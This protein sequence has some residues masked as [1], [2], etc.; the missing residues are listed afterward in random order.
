[1]KAYAQKQPQQQSSPNNARSRAQPLAASHTVNPILH[2]QRMIGNRAVQRLLHANDEGLEAGSDNS[3]TTRFAHDFTRIS[4][5]RSRATEL[6]NE[7][8]APRNGEKRHPLDQKLLFQLPQSSLNQPLSTT[9]YR[10]SDSVP[11]QSKPAE[12]LSTAED[13]PDIKDDEPM[14]DLSERSATDSGIKASNECPPGTAWTRGKHVTPNYI[15][16]KPAPI[17]SSRKYSYTDKDYPT[18]TGEV[19]VDCKA[20]VWRYQLNSVESKGETQIIYNT[21]KH[22]PAPVPTDDSGPLTN[23]TKSNWKE[24]VGD[25]KRNKASTADFWDSYKAEDAHENYHWTIEWQSNFNKGLPEV[26][27]EVG[28]LQVDFAKAPTAADAEKKLLRKAKRVFKRGVKRIMMKVNSLLD[29]PGSPPFRAQIPF[30][31]ALIKRVEDYANSNN[32]R[33]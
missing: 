9:K 14:S 5:H 4:V 17:R 20:K 28:K 25:F 32:W 6:K 21:E 13:E 26:E 29:T 33:K 15:L 12:P 27:N 1:M 16:N 8:D 24:I 3:A 7:P 11:G 10:T 23:V 22:Y 2:L 19:A 18:F 30:V 31:E